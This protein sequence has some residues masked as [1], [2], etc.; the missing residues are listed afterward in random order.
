[1]GP[2]FCTSKLPVNPYDQPFE[3]N[4]FGVKFC[5]LV[6]FFQKTKNN[7][8]NSWFSSFFLAIFPKENKKINYN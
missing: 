7:M 6:N 4:F 5:N 1:M 8:K 2:A 3:T